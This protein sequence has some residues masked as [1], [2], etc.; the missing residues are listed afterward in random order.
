MKGYAE[1]IVIIGLAFIIV[2]ASLLAG[3]GLGLLIQF[4][5]THLFSIPLWAIAFGLIISGLLFFVVACFVGVL[6]N[7]D[8]P[9]WMK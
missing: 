4:L 8:A 3:Y 6:L 7:E 9:D 5:V 1:R 2:G